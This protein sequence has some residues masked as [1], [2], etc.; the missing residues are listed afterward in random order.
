MSTKRILAASAALAV[1]ILTANAQNARTDVPEQGFYKDLFLDSGIQIFNYPPMPAALWLGLDTELLSLDEEAT[2]E[3]LEAQ[4]KVIC[5]CGE[6][7]NGCLLYPD[8]E[9]RFKAMYVYGGLATQHGRSLG[10]EGLDRIR[11]FFQ[12]GGSY[13]GS[14]AGAYLASV[15]INVDN[16]KKDYLGIWPGYSD[17][18]VVEDVY[19][20]YIIPEDS[21]LLKYYDFGGDGQVDSVMH[22]NG[23]VFKLWDSVPGTEMLACNRLDGS[24]LDGNPSIIAYK[25]SAESGRIVISGGH[26]ENVKDGERRS[27]MAA[28]LRY[29]M[30]GAGCATVKGT[31]TNGEVRRMDASTADI[32]PSHTMIGDGQ[33]HHFLL[34]LDKKARRV[35]ICLSMAYPLSLRVAEGT[36]AFKDNALYTAGLDRTGDGA[37][38]EPGRNIELTIKKLPAGDWYVCVQNEDRVTGD[39]NSFLLNGVP[40]TISASWK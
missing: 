31:L 7:L 21:P 5:G 6:D 29:A 28:L 8:G 20:D 1:A 38:M 11:T 27:L 19:P 12:G 36:F 18:V 39:G 14:C 23:P 17:E 34:H 10:A 32:D 15:G 24:P 13:V 22:W 3:N 40:Y 25:P 9:P 2:E 37:L 26:P 16:F 35:R 4:R 30:D 33:C